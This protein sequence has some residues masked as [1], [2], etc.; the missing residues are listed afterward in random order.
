VVNS[1]NI[2]LA[3]LKVCDGPPSSTF[4]MAWRTETAVNAHAGMA[5]AAVFLAYS[6]IIF[7]GYY[8]TGYYLPTA[9]GGDT[10]PSL[11]SQRLPPFYNTYSL[12]GRRTGHCV[13]AAVFL[14]Y[15]II[16]RKYFAGFLLKSAPEDL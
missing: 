16:M 9:V 13:S 10:E 8:F 7:A 5:F 12:R 3:P 11:M 15:E 4:L 14:M 6:N 2:D 1:I